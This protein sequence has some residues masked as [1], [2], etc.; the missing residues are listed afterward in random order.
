SSPGGDDIYDCIDTRRTDNPHRTQIKQK[1]VLN[2]SK[3]L[4]NH[5]L[6]RFTA[7]LLAFCCMFSLVPSAFAAD[8]SDDGSG[9][10]E[11]LQTRYIWLISQ[12]GFAV[13]ITQG[14]DGG[15]HVRVRDMRLDKD[16]AE[17]PDR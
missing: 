6:K 13:Q 10:G 4:K 9:D 5:A 15:H 1:G 2:L 7:F 11:D 3:L 16:Y 14:S 17:D 12:P 8:G